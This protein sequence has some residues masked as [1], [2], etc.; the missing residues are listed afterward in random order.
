MK[1]SIAV[2]F[3]SLAAANSIE[4]YLHAPFASDLSAAPGGGRVVWVLNE[5]GAR[6]LWVASAPDWKGRRLTPYTEDDG[7]DLG[8]IRWSA[9][10]RTLVYTRGGDLDTNGDNPNPRNRVETPEQ[11]VFAIAFDG[12]APRKL[13]EGRNAAVSKD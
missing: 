9:D 5:R 11:A 2:L 13:A 12:G 3:A 4:Q 7:Q 6:N 1:L 8:E 10:G